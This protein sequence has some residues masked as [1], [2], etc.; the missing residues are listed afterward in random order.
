[1]FKAKNI[2]TIVKVVI[3]IFI[4]V[5]ILFRIG[6]GFFQTPKSYIIWYFNKNYN[7]FEAIAEHLTSFDDPLYFNRSIVDTKL[8]NDKYF[9]DLENDISGKIIKTLQL[10]NFD[11][12]HYSPSGRIKVDFEISNF[13]VRV[14]EPCGIVYAELEPSSLEYPDDYVLEYEK[15]CDNWYY[16]Y[17]AKNRPYYGA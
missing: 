2:K 3:I 12:I 16:C 1:M 4:L 6:I 17:R 5:F 7:D 15:I 11:N 14:G 13:I 9:S 8:Y 10:G